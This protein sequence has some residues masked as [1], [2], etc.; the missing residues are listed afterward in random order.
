MTPEEDITI[1]IVDDDISLQGMLALTAKKA[2]YDVFTANDRVTAISQLEQQDIPVVLL[3]L[4]M[5]PNEHTT[6]E[7]LSVLDWIQ[8]NRPETHVVVLTGQEAG[9][10]ALQ[11]IN[12]GAFDFLEKP[13]PSSS[14]LAAIHRAQLFFQQR[15]RLKS[16]HKQY[17]IEFSVT[18]GLG[19]KAVR[20]MA[21]KKLLIQV[22]SDTD[23]N[24]HET[25]R[26]LGLKRE[27]VYY[28]IK[29]YQLK[30]PEPDA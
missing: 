1:L 23:F 14:L 10:A 18:E 22:L 24:I 3:D 15:Q 5:P 7:G 13:V 25:A 27:N 6:E 9:E 8:D 21:V 19:V 4:G 2:G 26:R 16:D 11:A 30:R 12:H 29:K 20:N 28:L 17:N